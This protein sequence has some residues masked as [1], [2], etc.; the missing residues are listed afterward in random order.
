[1]AV[2]VTKRDIHTT[3][4]GVNVVIPKGE[5]VKFVEGNGGGFVIEDTQLLIS[6]TGNT[7]DPIYRYAWISGEDV[8]NA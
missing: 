3:L 2:L 6:L 5:R 1:M 4:W 7:H 8:T